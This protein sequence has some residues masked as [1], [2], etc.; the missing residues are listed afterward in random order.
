M[1]TPNQMPKKPNKTR[2]HLLSG[3]IALAP[4]SWERKSLDRNS[5]GKEVVNTTRVSRNVLR[6]PLAQTVSDESVESLAKR[7]L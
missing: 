4:S 7:L 5:E 2:M 1:T 3:L 6:Y